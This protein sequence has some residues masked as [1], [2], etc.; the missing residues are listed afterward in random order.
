[1]PISPYLRQLRQM[2][3][4]HPIMQPAVCVLVLDAEGRVL[5]TRQRDDGA[6]H[7]IGG[8]LDPHEQPAAA[9]L[10]EVKEETGLDVV[11]ERISSV[12]AGPDQTYANGDRVLYTTIAF[13]AR[14]PKSQSPIVSDDEGLELRF[15]RLDELPEL[16]V[17]DRAS[18]ETAVANDP[19]CSFRLD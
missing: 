10:R 12:Y 15:F 1:M 8:A 19:R 2:V 6:W 18:I 11:L 9:A 5:L 4:H 7:T 16:H 13:V 3:G 17:C 14:A